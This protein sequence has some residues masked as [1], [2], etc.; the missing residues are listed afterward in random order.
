MARAFSV[1]IPPLFTPKDALGTILVQIQYFGN[2][3]NL[4]ALLAP[5][6]GNPPSLTLPSL[7]HHSLSTSLLLIYPPLRSLK[8]I[9][10]Y[11]RAL[12]GTMGEPCVD[13]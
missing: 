4:A 12:P 1:S 8:D 2:C 5:D 6:W 3:E 13:L 7:H 11:D 9:G 10:H